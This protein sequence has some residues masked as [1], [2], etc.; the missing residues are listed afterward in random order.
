MACLRDIRLDAIGNILF[1]S[2]GSWQGADQVRPKISEL[3]LQFNFL[4]LGH[5]AQHYQQR[6]GELPT[7]TM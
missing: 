5:F 3:A 2:K 6:F 7:D 1:D 4:H